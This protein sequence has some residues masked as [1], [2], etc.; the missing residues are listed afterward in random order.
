MSGSFDGLWVVVVNWNGGAEDNLRCLRS[1]LA[2][3]VPAARIVFVDNA[4][5]DGSRDAVAAALPDLLHIDNGSNLGFGEGANQGAR[6]ALASGAR[7]VAFVNNDLRFAE[8]G[9]CFAR[10]A[11]PWTPMSASDSSVRACSSTTAADACGAPVG[12]RITGRTSRRSSGT[13]RPTVR[14]G[15]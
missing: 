10:S 9:P 5:V 7:A 1:V 8:G 2:E 12:A 15:A 14:S 4:S 6:H 13:G 3:G 11:R